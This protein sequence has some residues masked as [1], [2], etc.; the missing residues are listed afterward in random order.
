MNAT[1]RGDDWE[2]AR[3]SNTSTRTEYGAIARTEGF[4]VNCGIQINGNFSRLSHQPKHSFRL[5][6]KDSWGPTKLHFLCSRA[7]R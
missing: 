4:A 3:P 5:V 7:T 6:F 2:R 1:A